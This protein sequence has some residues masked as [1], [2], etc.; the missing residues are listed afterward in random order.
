ME[1]TIFTLI[2]QICKEKGI[3]PEAVIATIE[4]AL[5]AAYQKDF[6]SKR[7]RSVKNIKAEFDLETGQARIFD[8]KMV[9]EDL[10]LG[11]EAAKEKKDLSK[12]DT[13][14]KPE[15]DQSK[16]TEKQEQEDKEKKKE[17]NPKTEITL[18][19]AKKIKKDAK[20]GDLIKTELEVP[21][22]Y[23]RI[24]AQTAKQVITQKLREA[25]RESLYKKFKEKEGKVLTGI[26]QK[27]IGK[28]ILIDIDL[29]TAILPPQE[30]IN[31]ESYTPGQRMK[32]FI[33]EV[34]QTN[35][36]PE[37]IV[38]RTYPEI[39]YQLFSLEVPEISSGSVEIKA[40]AREAG[41]RTKI[42]V[43]AK[44][45]NIDPIGSAIGQKGVRVQTIVSELGGEKIDIIQYDKDPT[46]FIGY[47]LSP[48]KVLSVDLN[49]KE[50]SAV[51][52]V[53]EDQYSL[54]IGKGG[55]NV[56]LATR[57]TGWKLDVVRVKVEEEK[58]KDKNQE[59]KVL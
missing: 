46:K 27:K 2:D 26:I 25:E 9:I 55:Q 36:G 19:E 48:A 42:A 32:V 59:L 23:G 37:V 57:L 21:T 7:D 53:K 51:V 20:I 31:T 35:K 8:V 49:E 41:T 47:A 11:L 12:P 15:L 40:V 38:S 43:E 56:R 30:Q 16:V 34:N 54:A 3:S 28:N 5:T 1:S 10:D 24:A 58:R 4:Q 17:F 33:L 39:V 29:V 44:Q 52:K 45:E 18:E 13:D 14:S 22:A 50:K 6:V